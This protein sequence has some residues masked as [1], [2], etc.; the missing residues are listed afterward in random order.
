MSRGGRPAGLEEARGAGAAPGAAVPAACRGG[1]AF[2]LVELLVVIAIIAIL[3]ALLLPALHRSKASSWRADCVGHLRQLALATEL[4]WDDN[5]GKCFNWSGGATNGG[6]LYWFGWISG[7]GGEGE[8][9]FDLS[10]GA[11]YPY[12]A[13]SRVRLCPSLNYA[14]GQFKLKGS[15]AICSFG[16]NVFLSPNILQPR[17]TINRVTRP[18]EAALFA[19]AAQVNDFQLPASHAN[20]MLEEWY[21]L[22]NPNPNPGLGYYPHGHFRHGQRA[23][24]VFCD[25]HVGPEKPVPDSIDPKLPSQFVARFRPE[26]LTLP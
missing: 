14:L 6:Q 19:D 18:T 24:V 23:N 21:Y 11:L 26:I 16:Y 10:A 1:G 22:D 17:T 3:A 7:T 4:Y 20:P 9:A 2:T 8:R 15:A 13:D 25:G 12:L 5:A